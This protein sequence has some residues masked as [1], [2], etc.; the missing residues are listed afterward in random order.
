MAEAEGEM[1]FVPANAR[2]FDHVGRYIFSL[3]QS[4]TCLLIPEASP[5]RVN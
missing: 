5:A 2:I 1:Y 3:N 4:T